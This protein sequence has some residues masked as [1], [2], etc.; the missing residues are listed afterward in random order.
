M[1]KRVLLNINDLPLH[2]IVKFISPSSL[3]IFKNLFAFFSCLF[4]MLSNRFWRYQYWVRN[5]YF[6]SYS[7]NKFQILIWVTLYDNSFTEYPVHMLR[8]LIQVYVKTYLE[9]L[10]NHY[11]FHF[12]DVYKCLLGKLWPFC[13]KKK[14]T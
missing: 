6:Q 3:E 13:N 2:L 8:L 4:S 11:N 14:E 10:G 9:P 12:C 1:L 5:A 7:Q